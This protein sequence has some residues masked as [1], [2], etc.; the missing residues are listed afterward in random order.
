MGGAMTRERT[1][2][3]QVHS[4]KRTNLSIKSILFIIVIETFFD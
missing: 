4:T 3:T 2:T 1:Q